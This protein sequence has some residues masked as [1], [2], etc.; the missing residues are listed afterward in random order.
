MNAAAVDHRAATRTSGRCC[1]CQAGIPLARR[2]RPR[3]HGVDPRGRAGHRRRR[4]A[5]WSAPRSWPPGTRQTVEPPRRRHRRRPRQH[6]PRARAASPR[7]PSS[8]SARRSSCSSATLDLP[9]APVPI[10]GP[11]RADRGA[12]HRL[13]GGPVAAPADRLPARDAAGRSSASTAAPTPC[14]RSARSP[15]SSSAT[16]TRCRR[17]RCAAAPSSSCTATPTAGPRAP[18]GSTTSACPTR[19]FSAPGTSED[20]AM[21]LAYEEGAELIVAVGTHNTMVEFLDKGRAGMASTFLVR[22]K[23]GAEP[24]RRQGR[25]PALPHARSAP[26]TSLWMI[27]AAVFTLGRGADAVRAGAARRSAPSG[28]RSSRVD[29]QLPLPHRLAH[30]RLPRPRHRPRA[31]HHVPR[32]RHRIDGARSDQL[33]GLESD[34]DRAQAPQRRAADA[35]STRTDEEADAARA[36]SSA[37][38]ST[39]ASSRATRCWSSSTRGRRRASW[40]TA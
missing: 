7:T 15:T 19:V 37:S 32:R 16:S 18:S 1:C 27:L 21:L 29:D 35:S 13:P 38:A 9:D 12:G 30:R 26:A 5:C 20:I 31:R 36:S 28:A 8:T 33:D 4:P 25:E 34:L 40:S 39:P 3:G 6:G 17:A 24:R 11:A 14:S 10:A 22:M 23:V 2:R